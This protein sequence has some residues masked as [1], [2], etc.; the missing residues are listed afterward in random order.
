MHRLDESSQCF[1]AHPT[2]A[3]GS[4]A[5]PADL[6]V[7]PSLSPEP[8][9]HD[10]RWNL[11]HDDGQT[12]TVPYTPRL[13]TSDMSTLHE[14][15]LQGVGVA[16]LPTL[17]VWQDCRAGRLVRVLPKWRPR[18]GIVHA[19]FPSRHGLL[20]SIPFAA[21]LPGMRM[22]AASHDDGRVRLIPEP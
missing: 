11:Q 22:R 6:A 3:A 21:R 16:Q 1:V 7:L 10:R 18:S 12:A 14:A 8:A 15:A 2:L 13:V 5:S 19:V 20:P 4:F 9:H 17:L